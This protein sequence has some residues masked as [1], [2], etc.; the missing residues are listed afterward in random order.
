MAVNESLLTAESF[1]SD[2]G[3]TRNIWDMVSREKIPHHVDEPTHLI[4]NVCKH[5]H[6]SIGEHLNHFRVEN[7]QVGIL[8]MS[9]NHVVGCDCFGKHDTL[10]KTFSK[11][12]NH[13]VLDT[14]DTDKKRCAFPKRKAC[15]F[16]NDIRMTTVK[17]RPSISLGTD[18]C[19]ESQK[20][21]GF[22][23][24]LGRELIHL[25]AC[26]KEGRDTRK[27]VRWLK[28]ENRDHALNVS[29]VK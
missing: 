25:T 28:K 8:V 5:A 18:L 21:T 29:A 23:L 7:N 24:S 14:I 10:S 15:G 19:L 16:L 9:N 26:D 13:Y 2:K 17:G 1:P 3:E 27:K 4:D 6:K 11:L 22:A 20:V 12:M